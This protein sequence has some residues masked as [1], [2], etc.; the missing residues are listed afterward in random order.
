M[1]GDE[2]EEFTQVGTTP[3]ALSAEEDKNRKAEARSLGLM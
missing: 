2:I 1:R 3:R